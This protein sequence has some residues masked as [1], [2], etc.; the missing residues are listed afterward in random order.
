MKN[1]WNIFG[2]IGLLAGGAWLF[3]IITTAPP[4][5]VVEDQGRQHVSADEVANTIYKSNPPTSGPHLPTWVKP[6]I[7][8]QPQSE[9]ELIH[10]LEHGYVIISYNCGVHLSA[11]PKS[12]IQNPKQIQIPYFKIPNVYAHEE[13]TPSG[14]TSAGEGSPSANPD[15]TPLATASAIND[16]DACK[17]LIRQLSDLASRKRLWKLIM[18]PRPQLDTTIAVTAWNRIDAFD[19]FDAKRIESFIDYWRDRG[20]ERTME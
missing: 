8:T 16:T 4:G 6:G 10:S 14:G 12:Q 15:N 3:R 11:N 13:L 19:S 18:V 7:Y 17:T 1:W 9:G 2:A 5:R 20:P